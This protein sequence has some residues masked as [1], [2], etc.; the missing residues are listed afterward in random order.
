MDAHKLHVAVKV[1]EKLL[2]DNAFGLE[3]YLLTQF[4][5]TLANAEEE[6]FLT[7]DDVGKPTN[8]F[9][10]TGGAE[11]GGTTSGAAI[12]FDDVMELFYSL[13]SS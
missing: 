11:D 8:I 9:A 13:K 2:Y 5:K 12:T 1:T 7:G 10:E 3:N 4:G 6:S